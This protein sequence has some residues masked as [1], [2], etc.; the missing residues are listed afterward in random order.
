VHVHRPPS[1]R[2]LLHGIVF[3]V[4]PLLHF[5]FF[6]KLEGGKP[7]DALSVATDKLIP[8]ELERIDCMIRNIERD[9]NLRRR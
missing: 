8:D 5:L 2:D 4:I 9:D 1:A 7:D 3:F 6:R